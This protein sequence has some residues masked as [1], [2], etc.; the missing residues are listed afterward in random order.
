MEPPRIVLL[1]RG[2]EKITQFT[3]FSLNLR[4]DSPFIDVCSG[5]GQ[6]LD[7]LLSSRL[8]GIGS[9]RS[10]YAI[11]LAQRNKISLTN[12][13]LDNLPIRHETV[14]LIIALTERHLRI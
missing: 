6:N 9:D 8:N 14:G 11:S 3:L 4:Q 13:D 5:T 1:V 10:V 12:A 7:T 2:K